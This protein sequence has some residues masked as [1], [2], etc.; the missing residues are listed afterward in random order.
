LKLSC[1]LWALSGPETEVVTRIAEAGFEQVDIRPFAF[2][3]T[4]SREWLANSGIQVCCV[5]ATHGMSDGAS[6]DSAD[7]WCA[8]A[9]SWRRWRSARRRW[10]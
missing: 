4:A 6:L 3:E 7:A 8:T 10:E 5:A 9:A 1:C 2:E